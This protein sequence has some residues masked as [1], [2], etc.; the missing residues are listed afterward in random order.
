MTYLLASIAPRLGFHAVEIERSP[1][2]KA[3]LE[4]AWSPLGW[5]FRLLH[6]PLDTRGNE[7]EAKKGPARIDS[8]NGVKHARGCNLHDTTERSWTRWARFA[9]RYRLPRSQD[10]ESSGRGRGRGSKHQGEQISRIP[11]N[12]HHAQAC[13][14]LSPTH[15]WQRGLYPKEQQDPQHTGKLWGRLLLYL[16]SQTRT[17][18]QSHVGES[19][20]GQRPSPCRGPKLLGQAGGRPA[21]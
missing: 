5:H 19:R 20:H 11:A 15:G 10:N 16:S 2:L 12:R 3:R 8:R 6:C 9:G 17:L 13:I 4:P 1:C 18:R 21:S 7:R 14:H